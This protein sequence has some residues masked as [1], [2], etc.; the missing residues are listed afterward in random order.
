LSDSTV[1]RN[2]GTAFAHCSIAYQATVKGLSRLDV[3]PD[4]IAADLDNS[5]EVLAEAVQ[6][7]M[8]KF[9]MPEPYERLKAVTRG[10]RL[11][12]QVYQEILQE[13]QLPAEAMQE[14]NELTPAKYIG[15]APELA[16]R[17]EH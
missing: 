6:T 1:L 7:V 4:A 12:A 3:N 5:W 15:C 11:S 8:R 10:R 9:S 16:K 14:L 2:L 13:R 17:S